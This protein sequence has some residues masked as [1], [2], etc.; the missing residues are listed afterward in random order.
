MAFLLLPAPKYVKAL[1]II[2]AFNESA[3]IY[4]VLKSLPKKIDGISHIDIVLIDDGST[5]KT[6]LESQRAQV[7]VV[8]HI[9]NR[10]LGAAIKTG[11]EIAKRKKA[12][13]AITFDGDGQ[14]NPEDIQKMAVLIIS[15]KAD[16]VIG[17]RFKE[18]QSVP[19]DRQVINWLANIATFALYG[20]RSTD[21][22]SGL[23][24]FS[25]KAINLIDFNADR[26]EFSSEILL[27]AKRNDLKVVE[28]PV[29]AIYTAYSR[30]KGQKNINAI[31]VFIRLLIRLLR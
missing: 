27:E 22:Q 8:S 4:K 17:S 15:K 5:D 12:D 14:H 3:V 28:V 9:I 6:V 24:A 26:M 7:K 25:K 10:G 11:L 18:K 2:P 16:L 1:I 31:F 30:E 19:F 21:S 13:I 23:R 29:D 20:A